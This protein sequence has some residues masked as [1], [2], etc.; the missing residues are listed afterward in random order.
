M[1]ESIFRKETANRKQNGS[2][3]TIWKAFLFCSFMESHLLWATKFS[4]WFIWC[5]NGPE[6]TMW[7]KRILCDAFYN[8]DNILNHSNLVGI[9]RCS[10]PSGKRWGE[11]SSFF[12]SHWPIPT[13]QSQYVYHG[14]NQMAD[15]YTH[16]CLFRHITYISYNMW[17]LIP[18]DGNFYVSSIASCNEEGNVRCRMTFRCILRKKC[19]M[20]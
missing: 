3:W 16:G 8:N 7:V 9:F 13:S 5:G 20:T 11:N 19:W 12:L 10:F 14:D 2:I 1:N 15:N 4:A 17:A 18:S 6:Q